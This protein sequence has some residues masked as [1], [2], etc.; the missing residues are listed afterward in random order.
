MSNLDTSR[1]VLLLGGGASTLAA[2]R[3][4]GSA[5]I[6]VYVSGLSGCRA[7]HSRHCAKAFPVPEP[8]PAEDFWRDLLLERAV[9]ELQ[10]AIILVGCDES[11]TFVEN[12]EDELRQRYVVEEFVTDLRH[13]ML[14]KYETLVRAR[15]AGIPTPA[16]WEIHSAEDVYKLRD[17]LRFPVMVKPLSSVGFMEK[18]GR[19]L[20]IINDSID[21]VAEKVALCREHGQD[22]LL[23]E[24][25]PG[26][27][28]LLSSYY[29]YRTPSGRSLYDY[30]KSIIRRWPVNRGG[31][32][33][34]QS[35]WLPETAAMGWK[36]FDSIGWQ[37]IGN[38]EFKRDLR[39]GQLKIIE[40]NGR[41]TAGHPL[42]IKG[43]APIDLA[44]YCHLTGQE[45][46][47]IENYSQ[48][49]RLWDPARDFMA[50]RQLHQRG[51]LTF[52]G[53]VRSIFS[54][55]IVLPFFSFDDPKP[56]ITEALGVFG[57]A[58]GKIFDPVRRAQLNA[59]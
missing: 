38:V 12:Y 57:R 26:P 31:A 25:I 51:E 40:V 48:A 5:G 37:G 9:P 33:F 18:F 47:R 10:G 14:D 22:V 7:M 11:L 49:L 41:L 42:I 3:S 58:L 44:I 36:L 27:D 30:T 29:T 34:H 8:R 32:C 6:T 50:F 16:F 19:K 46:P 20:F 59:D 43:G 1:P 4:L 17:E 2:V 24:M 52:A 35:E 21:E 23:V 15:E 56:G 28:S 13:A 53:W 39:D 55:S 45:V 54:Q